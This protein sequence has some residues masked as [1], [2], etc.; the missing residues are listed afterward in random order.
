MIEKYMPQ[1]LSLGIL[2]LMVLD[3]IKTIM[4]KEF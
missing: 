4:F 2:Y 3:K 1:V